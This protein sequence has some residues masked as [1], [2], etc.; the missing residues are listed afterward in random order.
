MVRGEGEPPSKAAQGL[1]GLAGREMD[2]AEVQPPGGFPRLAPHGG[3]RRF[4]RF[5]LRAA[6]ACE[7]D[8]VV[9]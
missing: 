2:P 3:A 7:P 8:P 6:R 4:E 1:G 5:P 9:G